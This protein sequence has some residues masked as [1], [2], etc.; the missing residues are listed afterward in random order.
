MHAL[1]QTFKF[2]VVLCLL[3][4]AN[5]ASALVSAQ[6]LTSRDRA[7]IEAAR[8]IITT[9]RYC[10]LITV[11]SGGRA[12]ARTM[13]PLAPDDQMM[14]WLG[15]NPRSRKVTEILRNPH[16]TLYYFD[17]QS[18]AYVTIQG[19]AR[20]VNAQKAKTQHWKEDWSAFYPDREKGFLLIAV[21]PIRMEVVN[22]KKGVVG[23]S[24][25]WR[26]PTVDFVRSKRR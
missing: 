23:D 9:A 18:Q 5:G 15:T 19:M 6:Q 25:E 2:L 7:L 8:E 11:T 3:P 20:L 13:D 12:E 21:T 26:P 24:I 10:T 16:V 1:L 17:L 22:V 14:I 4:L